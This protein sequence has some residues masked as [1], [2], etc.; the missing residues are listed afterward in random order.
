[1]AQ[2]SISSNVQVSMVSEPQKPDN[3]PKI[4]HVLAASYF[5]RPSFKYQVQ[6]WARD[7]DVKNVVFEI[8]FNRCMEVIE[9]LLYHPYASVYGAINK[10][11]NNSLIG[12][13]LL[14]HTQTREFSDLEEESVVVD[15]KDKP[16][17]MPETTD[18]GWR[19]V[20]EGNLF[21]EETG[22]QLNIRSTDIYKAHYAY[23]R[24]KGKLWGK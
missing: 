21:R 15:H 12:V 16:V 13:A 5:N 20:L 8:A 2:A 18:F 4:A 10:D 24:Y 3:L 6:S 1:M 14:I 17:R 11:E 9:R 19:A 23:K 22:R 7:E